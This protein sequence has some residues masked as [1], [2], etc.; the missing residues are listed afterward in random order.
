M[1]VLQKGTT[2]VLKPVRVRCG[3]EQLSESV[4]LLC[5]KGWYQVS[6]STTIFVSA[7]FFGFPRMFGPI[8]FTSV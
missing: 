8:M 7:V 4:S 2:V 1:M 6:W 5:F 3:W